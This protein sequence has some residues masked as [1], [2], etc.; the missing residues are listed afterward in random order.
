MQL[1]AIT[2]QGQVTRCLASARA[3]QSAQ[4]SK[5]PNTRRSYRTALLFD[6]LR[7]ISL[8]G[9]IAIYGNGQGHLA[10]G[11]RQ[12]S[13]ASVRLELYD[14]DLLALRVSALNVAVDSV[15]PVPT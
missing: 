4:N 3:I 5:S 11:C 12:R 15:N 6:I 7:S 9:T 14:R 1:P 10:E 2:Q 13:G 8:G